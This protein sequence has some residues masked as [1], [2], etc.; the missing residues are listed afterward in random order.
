MKQLIKLFVITLSLTFISACSSH[1]Q[2]S[3][4][5]NYGMDN[6]SPTIKKND[7]GFMQ[8]IYDDFI[9]NDWEPTISKNRDIKEKYMKEDQNST[10]SF[11]L[12]EYVDKA[13]AYV[14][15]KPSGENNSNVHKLE[16]MPVIGK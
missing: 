6:V 13:T 10:N 5:K 4:V 8:N 14:G 12:Q 15:E 9:K 7:E 16:Q 2:Q 11:T 3:E 1:I